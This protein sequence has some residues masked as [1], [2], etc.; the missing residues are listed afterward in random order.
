MRLLT[1]LILILGTSSLGLSQDCW[2]TSDT[3]LCGYEL[4]VATSDDA[5]IEAI[6]PATGNVA[7]SVTG[8]STLLQ[9]SACGEYQIL[10]C[11][12][13]GDCSDTLHITIL[14]PD[15]RDLDQALVVDLGYQDINC[16][17][18][19]IAEC[20]ESMVAIPLNN[21]G[22]P[23]PEWTFDSESTCR[24]YEVLT[25]VGSIIDGCIAESVSYTIRQNSTTLSDSLLTTIQD[26]FISIDSDSTV[27]RNEILA[28]IDSLLATAG[29]A[30][31]PIVNDCPTLSMDQCTDSLIID[32]IEYHIPVHLGGQWTLADLPNVVL[33]DSTV[34]TYLGRSYE[35]ILVPGVAFF[36]PGDLSLTVNEVF[37]AADTIQWRN[38][39]FGLDLRLQWEE[40]W[41]YDTVSITRQLPVDTDGD[42]IDCGGNFMSES[43]N[44]PGIPDFPC[45]PITI[46]FLDECE[47]D[48]FPVDYELS[49]SDCSPKT[50]ELQIFSDHFIDFSDD[51]S[52]LVN[53]GNTA[54]FEFGGNAVTFYLFDI[55]SGCPSEI[56]ES[57][58]Y[59]ID[60]V[61][62]LLSQTELNCLTPS[63]AL[64]AQAMGINGEVVNPSTPPVWQG[65]SGQQTGAEITVDEAGTYMVSVTDIY[66]CNYESN[67]TISYNNTTNTITEQ[68]TICAGSLYNYLGQDYPPGDHTITLDC[69]TE[70]ELSVV[71]QIPTIIEQAASICP[72]TRYDYQGASYEEGTYD[73]PI[74]PSSF[75]PDIIRLTVTSLP[76]ATLVTSDLTCDSRTALVTVV[77][78]DNAAYTWSDDQGSSVGAGGATLSTSESGLYSVTVTSTTLDGDICEEVLSTTVADSAFTPSLLAPS[79]LLLNCRA[80]TDLGFVSTDADRVLLLDSTDAEINVSPNL[81]L[82]TG[83]YRIRATSGIACTVEQAL[84]VDAA[85]VLDVTYDILDACPGQDDGGISNLSATGGVPPY[86]FRVNEDSILTN[87]LAPGEH[88]L[89]IEQADGCV[90]TRSLEVLEI[91]A[92]PDIT[93]QSISACTSAEVTVSLPSDP[94]ITY[95]WADGHP[96]PVRSVTDETSFDIIIDNGCE[97]GL[98]TINVEASAS[99][100]PFALPNV[101]NPN[102][103]I[104]NQTF[105]PVQIRP[106]IDYGLAIYDRLGNMVFESKDPTQ[107]WD[108]T[109]RGKPVLMGS[110]TYAISSIVDDC[111]EGPQRYSKTGSLL[112]IR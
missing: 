29:Q 6:C 80:V 16:P 48:D 63:I 61:Q 82:A 62:I 27:I 19:M 5:V 31:D 45:G 20:G 24:R 14:D 28:V 75:C 64:T 72:G 101:I 84:T 92:L 81:P 71:E 15:R 79:Q 42:C 10:C 23:T 98:T 54:T 25:Q 58:E 103:Y 111:A 1:L 70:V 18:N 60:Q 56:F 34:F 26:L 89:V 2:T 4:L 21:L 102:G 38:T 46:T 95:R 97:T 41:T 93:D 78:A 40:V 67:I 17:G 68:G 3:T 59:G 9:F 12:V 53:A 77:G 49:L 57:V 74:N 7:I 96:S 39:P 47:C 11:E 37:L 55:N 105:L 100:S 107:A 104:T 110:Y 91:A 13:G 106:V 69:M 52:N 8:D 83:L 43:F 22:T 66:G 86:T 35:V 76:A 108:G 85:E 65:P 112:V 73:I 88:L 87:Q 109:F 44:I 36:G 51:T 90:E 32:T 94:G 50:W 30:C 99:G 33:A